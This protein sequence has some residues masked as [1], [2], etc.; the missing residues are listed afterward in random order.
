M[1]NGVGMNDDLREVIL[2]R[3]TSISVILMSPSSATGDIANGIVKY[4]FAKLFMS[5]SE[6][7]IHRP[8]SKTS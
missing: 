4:S 5:I 2:L 1:F 8:T 6:R 3:C 7:H